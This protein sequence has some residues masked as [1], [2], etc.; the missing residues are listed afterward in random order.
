MTSTG[1]SVPLPPPSDSLR[2]LGHAHAF[3]SSRILLKW[4]YQHRL[5]KLE[6]SN[7]LV[8]EECSKKS[9]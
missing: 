7:K 2:F 8:K 1:Q 3:E 5:V 9:Q 4:V 6:Y